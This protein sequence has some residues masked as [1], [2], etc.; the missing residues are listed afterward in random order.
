MIGDTNDKRLIIEKELRQYFI[1]FCSN[2]NRSC[3]F[4]DEPEFK[5]LKIGDV[6]RCRKGSTQKYDCITNKDYY[7][8]LIFGNTTVYGEGHH[9]NNIF[10]I[11]EFVTKYENKLNELYELRPT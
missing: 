10:D 6:T 9:H 5:N 11:T 4:T 3:I 7:Q 8:V 2:K 1:N